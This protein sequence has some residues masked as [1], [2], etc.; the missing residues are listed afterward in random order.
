MSR[1][2]ASVCILRIEEVKTI[3]TS[4]TDSVR[5][6]GQK[7]IID[8]FKQWKNKNKSDSLNRVPKI[9]S[10]KPIFS[11]VP[12]LGY[13]LSSGLTGSINVNTAFYTS[14]PK[15]TNISSIT[16][17]F[18]YTEYKQMTIPV[19][20]NIWTRNN[21]Y[22]FIVDWRF[23]KYPQ[24]TYGLGSDTKLGDAFRLEYKHLRLHQ[25]VLKKI[26]KS[27]FVGLGFFYDKR[28]DIRQEEDPEKK[29][30][31][32]ETY[33]LGRKSSSVGP[34]ATISYDSRTNSINP[35][36]GLYTNIQFRPNMK[37]LGSTSNWQS[38]VI[39]VRKYINLPRGSQN[40]LAFWNYNWLTIGGKPPYLDLPSTGWDPSNNI[41]RGYI[42]G[43]FR[44]TNLLYFESE[45]RFALTR[46]GLLGGVVFANAQSVSDWPSKNFKKIAPAGGFGIRIKVNKTSGANIAIDYGFGMDGSRGLFVNL[47][48]VF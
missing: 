17:N 5:K 44:S 10:G 4:E 19:Q 18:I 48:E 43:R 39:D 33:G 11:I 6:A 20:A 41:G 22:N 31:D 9:R 16:T 47:G 3:T 34:V 1:L 45:Y 35:L 7:D 25:S 14:N 36:H 8:I 37:G 23:F 13:T 30:E 26:G 29:N 46:N 40:T 12:A 38:L 42:Q 24:D 15:T 2:A 27:F 21:N 28:W 32:I